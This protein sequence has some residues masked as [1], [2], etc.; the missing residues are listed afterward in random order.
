[1]SDIK[2]KIWYAAGSLIQNHR[3]MAE[4]DGM[5]LRE[6]YKQYR[7]EFRQYDID[8]NITLEEELDLVAKQKR[9]TPCPWTIQKP[10]HD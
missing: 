1:M 7:D 8:V 2:G 10:K 9:G 4:R 6:W 5:T 3:R